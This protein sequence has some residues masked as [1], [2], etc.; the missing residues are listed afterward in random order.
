MRNYLILLLVL[1]NVRFCFSQTASSFHATCASLVDENVDPIVLPGKVGYG[2]A[3][4]VVGANGFRSTSTAV[5]LNP[6]NDPLTSIFKS[7]TGTT[8]DIPMDLSAYWQP[9]LYYQLASNQNLIRVKDG[10]ALQ[11]Y[12]FYQ[13]VQNFPNDFKVV[14]GKSTRTATSGDPDNPAVFFEYPVGTKI[15]DFPSLSCG[16][17]TML[18]AHVFFP[19]CGKVDKLTGK[20]LV[21]PITGRYVLGYPTV[22]R[23]GAE[24][25]KLQ[26]GYNYGGS[27]CPAGDLVFPQ[28]HQ[29]FHYDLKNVCSSGPG[30]FVWANGNFDGRGLHADF[31]NGWDPPTMNNIIIQCRSGACVSNGNGCPANFCKATPAPVYTNK[32]GTFDYTGPVTGIPPATYTQNFWGF[33]PTV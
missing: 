27:G 14:V 16:T 12:N 9:I 17:S 19:N 13:G 24:K 5:S 8:C 25:P 29:A 2:H 18:R 22:F 28:L 20:L 15:Y 32:E 1:D 10:P 30:R 31:L 21:D 7:S 3:H 6:A 4:R 33:V 11:Y 26:A 23:T